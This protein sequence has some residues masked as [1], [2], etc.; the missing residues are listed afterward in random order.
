MVD[1]QIAEEDLVSERKDCRIG[2][3]PQS[4]GRQGNGGKHRVLYKGPGPKLD[5]LPERLYQ[6]TGPPMISESTVLGGQGLCCCLQDNLS[7]G[8]SYLGGESSPHGGIV[9][10]LSEFTWPIPPI[11]AQ[12]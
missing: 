11:L 7:P 1:R 5:V 2:P 8:Q 10:R 12:H 9:A 4:Q 3:D 6:Q